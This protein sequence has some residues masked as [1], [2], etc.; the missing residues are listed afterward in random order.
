MCHWGRFSLTHH[1]NQTNRK[2]GSLRLR[3][4]VF[5]PTDTN[6]IS[7][8]LNTHPTSHNQTRSRRQTSCDTRNTAST[9]ANCTR[10]RHQTSC[11]TRN[12]ASTAI[13]GLA[14]ATKRAAT[15]TTQHL[16]PQTALAVA[17]MRADE[18]LKMPMGYKCRTKMK[19]R[20]FLDHTD[21]SE[22]RL[23]NNSSHD[24]IFI[25]GK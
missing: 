16:Q 21:L 2:S 5:L 10:S 4:P 24:R 7:S 15:R 14:V 3:L 20:L 23:M 11:D 17:A 1:T 22:N 18:V 25:S 9:A 19:I 13:T 6:H 12:T 8:F